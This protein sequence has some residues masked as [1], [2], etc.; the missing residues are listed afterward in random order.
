[1][2]GE[3]GYCFAQH[4]LYVWMTAACRDGVAPPAGARIETS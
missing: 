1:L 3:V 2:I 4:I